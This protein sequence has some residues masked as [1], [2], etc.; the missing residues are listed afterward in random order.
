MLT[1]IHSR[2]LTFIEGRFTGR[3]YAAVSREHFEH[4]VETPYPNNDL[5][6]TP[7]ISPQSG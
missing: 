3:L 6:L 4:K 1:L 7:I 2:G 5:I